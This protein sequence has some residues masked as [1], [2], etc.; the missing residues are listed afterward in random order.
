[1]RGNQVV[2]VRPLRYAGEISIIFLLHSTKEIPRNRLFRKEK[3]MSNF[4]YL[5]KKVASGMRSLRDDRFVV[6]YLLGTF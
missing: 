6:S 4:Y 3:S 5:E 1:M 2:K